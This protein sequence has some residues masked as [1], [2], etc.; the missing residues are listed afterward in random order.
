MQ[1][2]QLLHEDHLDSLPTAADVSLKTAR[3]AVYVLHQELTYEYTRPIRD[4]RQRLVIV[5]RAV[6]GDQR[7]IAH[8][9]Q[10]GPDEA[11]HAGG[12]AATAARRGDRSGVVQEHTDE[13][14]NSVVHVESQAVERSIHFRVRAVVRRSVG[15]PGSPAERAMWSDRVPTA[16]RLTTPDAALSDAAADLRC[17]DVAE[18]VHRV[19]GYVHREVTYGH[20]VTGVRTTAAEAW[21]G[22]VGV[23]QDMAHVMIAM[24]SALGVPA[25][26]VSGHLVGDGASHAWVEVLDPA[27]DD[28]ISI[29]PTH[30]RRTDLRYVTTAVGRDYR[31]VAPT[32][33][34][35]RSADARGTLS[36][37]KRIRLADVA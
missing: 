12:G 19:C 31:D 30:D 23:C 28:V 15:A 5:P 8:H 20:G 18:L 16:T 36:V 32:S 10:V 14:G 34:T 37:R 7:R 1:I 13:F 29:D 21:A 24:C 27:H 9:V 6:H 2:E 11:A 26:Y 3:S 35:F 4:V 33:G 25:R 17:G 22:R